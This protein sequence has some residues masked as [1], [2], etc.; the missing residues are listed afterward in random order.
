[1]AEKRTL[2]GR[3]GPQHGGYTF[4]LD[5]LDMRWIQKYAPERQRV[6]SVFI[7]FDQKSDLSQ[8]HEAIWQQVFTLLTGLTMDEIN[9]L[10][11]IAIENPLTRQ[12]VYNSQPAYV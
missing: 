10:G 2:I 12:E 1:M 9:E 11:G 6:S 8:I 7:G 3:V 4:R 5:P